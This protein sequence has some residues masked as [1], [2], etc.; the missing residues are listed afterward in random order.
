MKAQGEVMQKHI[1]KAT[2]GDWKNHLTEAHLE[3]FRV[4]YGQ[5]IGRLGY[6]VE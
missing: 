5:A 4:R 2:V 1:R 6:R 3:I